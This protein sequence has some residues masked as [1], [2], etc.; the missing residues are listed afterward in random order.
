MSKNKEDKGKREEFDEIDEAVDA[1]FKHYDVDGNGT[2]D[3]DEAKVFFTELFESVGDSMPKEAHP[4]IMEEIDAN[5]D[6]ELSRE[7]LKTI[8]CEAFNFS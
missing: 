8:M 6:G 7:E 1:I 4:L 2:L 5:G 3:K